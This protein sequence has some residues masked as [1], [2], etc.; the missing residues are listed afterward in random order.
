METK[1]LLGQGDTLFLLGNNIDLVLPAI[2]ISM[3]AKAGVPK[4]IGRIADFISKIEIK[5][6]LGKGPTKCEVSIGG[7]N[8]FG[9]LSLNRFVSFDVTPD[10]KTYPLFILPGWSFY[11]YFHLE[12]NDD[13]DFICHIGAFPP[14]IREKICHTPVIVQQYGTWQKYHRGFFEVPDPKF[15]KENGY[16]I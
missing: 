10:Q 7:Q 15:L 11:S 5:P 14:E 4:S 9:E 16:P 12:F 8:N 6:L 13:V 3:K 2:H 1:T